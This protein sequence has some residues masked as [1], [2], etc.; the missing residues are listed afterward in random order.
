[1]TT[2]AFQAW[3]NR[4]DT[5]KVTTAEVTL[6]KISD[7]SSLTLYIA[8]EGGQWDGLHNFEPYLKGGAAITHRAQQLANGASLV[9]YGDLVVVMES[10][11]RVD[12]Y[13][14]LSWADIQRD[15]IFEGGQVILRQGGPALAYADWPQTQCTMGRPSADGI[16]DTIPL[17]AASKKV[18][19]AKIPPRKLALPAT[20]QANHAYALG[21]TYAPPTP[22]GHY[23]EITVAGTSGASEPAYPTTDNQTAADG[24]A[25]ITCRTI[26]KSSQDKAIPLAWGWGLQAEPL[27]FDE[28]NRRYYISDPQYGPLDDVPA[29]YV[30]GQAQSGNFTLSADKCILTFTSAVSGQVTV[31]FKGRRVAGVFKSLVGDLAQDI[32]QALGSVATGDL[33]APAFAAYSTAMPYPVGLYLTAEESIQTVLDSLQTGLLST[34]GTTRDGRYTVLYW[35]PPSGTPALELTGLHIISGRVAPEE[36]LYHQVKIKGERRW[37]TTS[38]PD[39]SLGQ[40]RQ[41]WLQEQYTERLASDPAIKTAY[42][43]AEETDVE[44]HL[45]QPDDCA[46]LAQAWLAMYGQERINLEITCKLQPLSVELGQVVRV[47]WDRHGLDQGRLFRVAGL[48]DDFMASEVTLTLWG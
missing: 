41:F 40:D 23:Y 37:T 34:W 10:G 14:T 43:L 12:P 1:M 16:E 33:D 9:S 27:L 19:E 2:A 6:R 32:L 39:A 20:R 7:G 26:P 11:P 5:I 38:S 36:R 24:T 31:D 17:F 15:F 46:T 44:T 25:T 28:T 3:A 47:T 30:N 4:Y 8:S 22:N 35:T 13:A 29:V 42:P 45:H 21:D 48:E 18:V